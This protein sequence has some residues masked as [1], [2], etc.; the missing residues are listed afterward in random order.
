MELKSENFFV[1][2]KNIRKKLKKMKDCVFS[3]DKTV[4]LRPFSR[5]TFPVGIVIIENKHNKNI[6]YKVS[7]YLW[8]L[9]SKSVDLSEFSW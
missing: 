6:A 9:G 8:Q 7:T 2:K 4:V 1:I 3:P 5:T